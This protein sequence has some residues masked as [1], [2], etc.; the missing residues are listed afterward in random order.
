MSNVP[1][2]FGIGK[3]VHYVDAN[4]AHHLAVIV[5]IGDDAALGECTLFVLGLGLRARVFF[6]P[7]TK[8][9]NTWYWREG[10]LMRERAGEGNPYREL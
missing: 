5:Q 8:A 2:R 9:Q 7:D 1:K 4:G 6:D 3:S 10:S